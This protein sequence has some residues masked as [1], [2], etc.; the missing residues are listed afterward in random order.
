MTK[1][2]TEIDKLIELGIDED[3]ILNHLKLIGKSNGKPVIKQ[4][5]A[6][7]VRNFVLSTTGNFMLTDVYN[8][9]QLSTRSDK[10]NVSMIMKR[11]VEQG[12]I[13]KYGKKH[14]CYRVVDNTAEEIDFCQAD[15]NVLDIRYPFEIEKFVHTYPKSISI[16]A[17]SSNSG[18]TAFLLNVV[19]LNMDRHRIHYFSS[20]MGGNELKSRLKKFDVPLQEWKKANWRERASDF[21]DVIQ[22]D[23][24]NIIDFLELHT[25]FFLVGGMIKEIFDKLNNGI[26]IIAIQKNAGNDHGLG[27]ARSLEKARLYLAMD[28]GTVKIVKGKNWANEM[29]NPNGMM[30]DFKLVQGCK[31]ISAGWHEREDLK[32]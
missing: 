2:K 6:E 21:A 5:L 9:Q 1:A 7:S 10:Q 19:K 14:G 8:S 15:D 25:D 16:I 24:I 4:S 20:E 17:G 18:K 13:E 31:F 26:A 30:N 3:T 29:V 23:D 32:K 28:S 12:V 27:G 11:L 22:P